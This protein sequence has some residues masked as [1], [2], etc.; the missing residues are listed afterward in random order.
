MKPMQ[1]DRTSNRRQFL[2]GQSAAQAL[3][4][5]VQSA[6]PDVAEPVASAPQPYLVQLKRW[7][8]ACN[9]EV[10]LNAGQHEQATQVALEGLDLIEL[11]EAQLT[12]YRDSSELMH[13]NRT[14]AGEPVRVEPR[15]FGL[16][17][18]A[19][20]LHRETQGAFDIT[21]GPLT[22]VWGFYRRA[23][24]LPA[25]ADLAAALARVDGRKL[26]LDPSAQT[27]RFAAEGMELNLGAIGKGYA[28]DRSAELMAAAGVADFLWHGGQSSVLARGMC[29]A[30]GPEDRGWVVGVR[31]PLRPD[32]RLA[33]IRLCDAALATSG[34]SVQFFRH[35]GKRYGHILDPRTGWPAEGMFSATVIARE[36]A[37]ADALSTAF[38]VLGVDAAVDYCG[39]H[40]GVGALLVHPSPSGSKVEVT[41][42]GLEPDAWRLATD[43]PDVRTVAN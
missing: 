15:L 26:E 16:L 35:G 30:N 42:A 11:L 29:A 17:E 7:A 34:S 25:D 31:D 14:A 39:T 21:S 1:P 43:V 5:L 9:F 20:Q 13:I 40:P 8:M 23:G 2:K 38:Y 3:G 4:N 36:A 10:Y 32:R 28:L 6:V 18:R 41:P 12:V 33:E 27:V 22:K 37:D 19:S 24:S